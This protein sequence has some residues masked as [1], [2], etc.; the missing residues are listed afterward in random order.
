MRRPNADR[1]DNPAPGIRTLGPHDQS[2]KSALVNHAV[3]RKGR[4]IVKI[5]K[6]VLAKHH[7]II[8]LK[9]GLTPH[10]KTMNYS[11][12]RRKDLTVYPNR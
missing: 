4:E 8:S 10:I 2:A 7:T 12:I 1:E 9:T 6:K 3:A 5:C 11:K